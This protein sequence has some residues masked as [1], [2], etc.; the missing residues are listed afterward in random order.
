MFGDHKGHNVTSLEEGYKNLQNRISLAFDYGHLKIA[1]HNAKL[2]QVKHTI[3]LCDDIEDKL[4]KEIK[5]S[6]QQLRGFLDRREKQLLGQV[7]LVFN[8]ERSKLEEAKEAWENK[9][10]TVNKIL[11]RLGEYTNKDIELAEL[12]REANEITNQLDVLKADVVY[13]DVAVPNEV[14]NSMTIEREGKNI[15]ISFNEL[16]EI[17]ASYMNVA[18]VQKYEYSY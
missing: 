14:V 9:I 3:L 18:N 11:K 8:D 4:N 13:R 2:I 16:K 1:N 12:M 5:D 10:E 17:I 7:S 15:V 6:F